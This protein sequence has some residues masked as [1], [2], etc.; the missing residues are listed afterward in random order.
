[1]KKYPNKIELRKTI[2]KYRNYRQNQTANFNL[3]RSKYDFGDYFI[4]FNVDVFFFDEINEKI[5]QLT[6]ETEN[7]LIII[8][9]LN[10]AFS[11]NWKIIFND[12][13][14]SLS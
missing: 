14:F 5:N 10:L 3:A 12:K 8:S 11:F 6:K 9:G 7:D 4:P 2:R 1:M 13:F